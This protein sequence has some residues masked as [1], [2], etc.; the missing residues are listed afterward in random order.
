[1]SDETTF[2]M[3]QGDKHDQEVKEQ[4]ERDAA[5][6]AIAA[7]CLEFGF[8]ANEIMAACVID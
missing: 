4:A 7:L 1:M 3:D 8:S 6:S 2:Q 5:L